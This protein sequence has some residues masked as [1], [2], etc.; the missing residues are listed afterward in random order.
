MRLM[1]SAAPNL[2]DE[3]HLMANL[4]IELS[5]LARLFDDGRL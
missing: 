4:G 2:V 5:T 3:G 1:T